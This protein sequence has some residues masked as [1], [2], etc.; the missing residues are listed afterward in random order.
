MLAPEIK[1][2]V[3]ELSARYRI[4]ASPIRE[5]LSQLAASGFVV[6][7]GKK[8]SASRRSRRKISIDITES[9]KFIEAEAVRLAIRHADA[10]WEDEIVASYHL[11]ERQVV[12]FYN[13]EDRRS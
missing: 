7:K 13:G 12:R 5:A 6:T 10:N 9:R 3:R 2:K 8:A 1:L 4:S 11:F